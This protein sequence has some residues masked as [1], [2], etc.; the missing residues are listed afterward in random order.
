MNDKP[1]IG[2]PCKTLVVSRRIMML[3]AITATVALAACEDKRVKS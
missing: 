2:D 1:Q 3:T